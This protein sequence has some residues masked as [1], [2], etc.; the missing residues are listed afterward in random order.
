MRL[1]IGA[2]AGR[3]YVRALNV[4]PEPQ[5]ARIEL[6]RLKDAKTGE[7][8]RKS[9]AFG[10]STFEVGPVVYLDDVFGPLSWVA[11]WS[12]DPPIDAAARWALRGGA[13]QSRDAAPFYRRPPD[14]PYECQ[15]GAQD[16][17]RIRVRFI[18]TER[19]DIQSAR[20][21][22]S[23]NACFDGA[24]LAAVARWIYS[25]SLDNGAPVRR[26]YVETTVVFQLAGQ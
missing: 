1:L 8:E 19:G 2:E 13:L 10:L 22:E 23:S 5:T 7:K 18:V 24:A 16:E 3:S 9:L 11:G 17:E 6:E 15:A 14:F 20:P 4:G 26:R 12:L 25:P 21:V